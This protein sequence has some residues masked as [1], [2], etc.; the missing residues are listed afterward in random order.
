MFKRLSMDLKPDARRVVCLSFSTG[1][2]D[3]INRIYKSIL[4][5]SPEIAG[6]TYNSFMT[7]FS[8][9]HSD[10]IRHL[11][12]TFEQIQ[13]SLPRGWKLSETKQLLLASY[14]LK[15]YSVE[16]AA[17]FNPSLVVHPVQDDEHRLRILISLRATGEGHI[18]SIEFA[19]GYIDST[20]DVSIC[21]REQPCQLP[22]HVTAD[23]EKSTLAFDRN[24]PLSRQVIFPLTADEANGIEDVRFVHFEED[25]M[26]YGTF[27]A[28]DGRHI[29]SKLIRTP[30][31][32]GYTIYSLSGP[33]I[34]DKG[35]ALFPRKIN[36]KY[37][38]IS[39]QDGE[40]LR[41]MYSD[42]LLHWSETA[43]LQAPEFPWQLGKIGNCGSPI[44]VD[45]GWI[46]WIHG[47]GPL[48]KYVIGACLLDKEN[49]HT[50]IK[51]TPGYVLSATGGEREGYVPNV[52]Y[53]CGGI[54]HEDTLYLPY[55]ISDISSG[56][57]SVKVREL[58]DLM[59]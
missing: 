11:K 33:A 49:P 39:R 5:L 4:A 58:L 21:P 6:D 51:R 31:F 16:A 27:T 37:A 13:P 43:M 59:E 44:E 24:T 45:E 8:A 34:R 12:S 14:F 40:N 25:N 17:L 15:E 54:R 7:E 2:R 26:Y 56:M 10:F 47:V 9:R 22:R 57:V 55:A 28:Y 46:L 19:E 38:M 29:K 36:N 50:I 1:N 42:D 30:D 48:R 18:S 20:G 3:T 53:S 32:V 41:I 23:I 52:V 35:M